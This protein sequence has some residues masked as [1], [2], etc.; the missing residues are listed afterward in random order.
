MYYLG[1]LSLILDDFQKSV[2]KPEDEIKI[3]QMKL[4]FSSEADKLIGLIN[5]IGLQ[6]C[7]LLKRI[8]T[9]DKG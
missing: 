6:N 9:F 8:K 1:K 7:T 2:A 3:A 4:Q 5:Q